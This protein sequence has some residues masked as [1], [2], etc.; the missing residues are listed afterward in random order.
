MLLTIR[1]RVYKGSKIEWDV[2]E[3]AQPYPA[4]RQP[5]KESNP[6]VKKVDK[7][8]TNMYD[9]L[10]DPLGGDQ[11]DDDEHEISPGF[12]RENPVGIAA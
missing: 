11:D 5:R 6:A 3:C 7:K 12:H 4:P 2:D 8:F 10:A 1:A 9:L